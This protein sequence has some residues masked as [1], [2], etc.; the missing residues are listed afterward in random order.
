MKSEPQA[1]RFV[2]TDQLLVALQR[3]PDA[4]EAAKEQISAGVA[5]SCARCGWRKSTRT[6][7]L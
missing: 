7:S 2:V 6:S 1:L 3:V 4:N 5:R